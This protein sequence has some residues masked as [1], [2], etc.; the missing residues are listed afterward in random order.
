MLEIGKEKDM[1]LLFFFKQVMQYKL[2]YLILFNK[3]LNF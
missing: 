1:K 3:Y 2:Q